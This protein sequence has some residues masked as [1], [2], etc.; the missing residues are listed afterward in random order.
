MKKRKINWSVIILALFVT[1]LTSCGTE[2]TREEKVSAIIGKI[3]SPFFVMNSSPGNLIEKSGA[4]DGALPYTQEMLLGFFIEEEITGVDYDMNVQV[5][6]GRGGGFTPNFYGIF[7][8]KNEVAFKELLE[9]EAGAEIKEKEGYQ[10]VMKESDSY[11][12]VWNDEFAIATSIPMDLSQMFSGGSKEGMATVDKTIA[13]ITAAEEGEINE[14]YKTFLENDADI[15]MRFEGKPFYGYL[16]D[17]SMGMNDDLE[18]QRA[19]VEE[20]NSDLFINFTNGSVD[21][22][23]IGNLSERLKEEFGF[24]G[25]GPVDQKLLTYGDSKDPMFTMAYNIDLTKGVDYTKEQMSEYDYEDLEDELS[26]FGISLD[27]A[28]AGLTG[29]ILFIVDRLEM[30]TQIVDWGYD[31][32][33][34]VNEPMPVFGA[35]FGIA[36]IDALSSLVA[37]SDSLGENGILKQGDAFLVISDDVLFS[38]NDS[39]WAVKVRDGVA[40]KIVDKGDVLGTEPFGMFLDFA[41][42]AGME[43]LDDAEVLV[44][45]LKSLKGSGN[46]NEMNISLIM[47]DNTRNA[48]RILT[49]NLGRMA[50][51]DKGSGDEYEQLLNELDEAA[52]ETAETESS[53]R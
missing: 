25:E 45:K 37:A 38:T 34:E 22:N 36:D 32:P 47:N 50:E 46:M 29:D 30:K 19:N 51:G 20:I 23:W 40:S 28:K 49:E 15:S 9:T 5:V 14:G 27:L 43:E 1:G 52:A 42:L 48:L 35:V 2:R 33:Y 44:D 17:V 21:L 11:V 31:E 10:Y 13:L 53:D 12:I 3:D 24:L 4:A 39:L 26:E 18:E 41:Q 8:L 7:K 16:E 6:V